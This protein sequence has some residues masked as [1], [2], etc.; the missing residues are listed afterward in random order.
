MYYI[1]VYLCGSLKYHN[2]GLFLK[3]S[4]TDESKRLLL[5]IQIACLRIIYFNLII[6]FLF[7][8]RLF[9][10][11]HE[12]YHLV[13]CILLVELPDFGYYNISRYNSKVDSHIL[14]YIYI[15]LGMFYYKYIIKHNMKLSRRPNRAVLDL[16]KSNDFYL[17]KSQHPYPF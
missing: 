9:V 10:Y 4:E 3:K 15:Y 5:N 14:L 1:Y 16:S 6:M 8:R 13:G 12:L 11:I 2:T 17:K 7:A